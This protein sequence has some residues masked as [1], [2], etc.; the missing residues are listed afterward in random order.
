MVATNV[1]EKGRESRML[2]IVSTI[3]EGIV[4]V[5]VFTAPLPKWMLRLNKETVLSSSLFRL[6]NYKQ[7][8]AEV[9][10][11]FLFP[12]FHEDECRAA[13]LVRDGL[14]NDEFD[15]IYTILFGVLLM[16]KA[17]K[18]GTWWTRLTQSMRMR[19]LFRDNTV[20]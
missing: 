2:K 12:G 10:R 8:I 16:C 9:A 1:V 11:S 19:K 20:N 6:G 13:T 5:C 15:F 14:V 7:L 17:S 4:A 3:A 18:L